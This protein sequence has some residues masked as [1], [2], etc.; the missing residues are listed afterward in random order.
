MARKT[1]SLDSL[2]DP[3]TAPEAVKGHPVEDQ[4]EHR[5]MPKPP[6]GSKPGYRENKRAF[7]AWAHTAC[8]KELKLLAVNK[9]TTIQALLEEGMDMVFRKYGYDGYDKIAKQ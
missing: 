7:T 1:L 3:Q 9:E 8:Y 2:V 6:K 5:T 4:G